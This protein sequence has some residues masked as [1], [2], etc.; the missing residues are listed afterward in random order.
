[1]KNFLKD[2]KIGTKILILVSL[3]FV[4]MSLV[5]GLGLRQISAAGREVTEL[6]ELNVAL[7]EVTHKIV[8]LHLEENI[9]LERAIQSGKL[10]AQEEVTKENFRAE[11]ENFRKYDQMFNQE[12]EKGRDLLEQEYEKHKRSEMKEEILKLDYGLR[13]MH[14]EFAKHLFFSER[15]LNLISQGKLKQ[16]EA[17]ES[18]HREGCRM[19]MT[20]KNFLLEIESFNEDFTARAKKS[21]HAA[22]VGMLFISIFLLLFS[23]VLGI[24][25]SRNISMPIIKLTNTTKL[26]AG[27]DLTQRM[28]S[29]SKDEIGA[30]ANS[31]NQMTDEIHKRNE[32]LQT[33]NE[34]IRST[35]EELET[36]NEELREKTQNLERFHKIVVGRELEMVKLK[37]EINSL[38]KKSGQPKKYKVS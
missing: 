13:G 22:M 32:E 18:L 29:S 24:F 3:T 2:L 15:I 36:S 12:I 37:G 8:V 4:L 17:V 27:G 23:L 16:V 19:D 11:R 33:M 10:M 35:N 20:V 28:D 6:I 25:V 5:I 31:F 1:M 30:L 38:L 21:E 7:T 9:H 14:K 34:E 26:V